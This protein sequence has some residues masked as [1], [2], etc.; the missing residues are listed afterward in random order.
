LILG[1]DARL[2]CLDGVVRTRVGYAWGTTPDPTYHRPGGHTETIEIDYDADAVSYEDL[3]AVFWASHDP[4]TPA[5]S[6]QCRSAIFV[7]D[8]ERTAAENSPHVI[9][10]RSGRVST[11][12]EPLDRFCRAEDYHQKYRL[13]AQR[14]VAGEL[15][16]LSPDR[17][18]VRRLDRRRT[19]ERLAGRARERRA[20]RA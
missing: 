2:G 20:T 17:E 8:D 10:A 16:A 7:H 18:R 15:R 12:L 11:V 3:L 14:R 19:S 4:R 13:R 9:G 6:R 5:Y 1:P